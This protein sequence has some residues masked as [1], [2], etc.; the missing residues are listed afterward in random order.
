MHMGDLSLSVSSEL[1]ETVAQQVA[2]RAAA[3]LAPRVAATTPWMTTDEAVA[4]T[5]IPIGTFEKARGSRAHP[6]PYR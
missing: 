3:L 4:Y 5:R 2:Q 6:V 1:V